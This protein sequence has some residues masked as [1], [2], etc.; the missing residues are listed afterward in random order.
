MMMA[1]NKKLE[2]IAT[3]D[4]H[5]ALFPVDFVSGK[6]HLPSMS[7]I[8]TYVKM[9]RHQSDREILLLDNGDYLQGDPAVYYYNYIDTSAVHIGAK[10]MNYMQYD[11]SCAGNHDFEAG[12]DVFEK[13]VKALNFP[14]MA[15]NVIDEK[16]G[17]TLLPAYT[18]YKR[19]GKTIAVIAL[20]TPGIPNWLPDKLIYDLEFE[21]MIKFAKYWMP[22][23][24]EKEKPDLV[25]GLCHAGTDYTFNNQTDT[26]YKNENAALLTAKQVEGFDIIIAGHDHIGH[27]FTITNKWGKEVTIIAPTARAR[28]FCS[29]E[30]NFTPYGNDIKTHIYTTA[31]L[32]ADYSFIHNFEHEIK[33]IK[34]FFNEPIGI[35]S[36][37]ISAIEG[38]F[39][40]DPLTNLI[41]KVQLEVTDAEISFAAPLSMNSNIHKGMQYRKD[42]F[43]LYKYDNSLYAIE[44]SGK[45]IKD[46]LEFSY[47]Q[48]FNKM[49]DEDDYLLRYKTDSVGNITS[50]TFPDTYTPAYNYESAAGII[51]T[52]DVSKDKGERINI[53]SMS[54]GEPFDYEKIYKVAINSY[55]GTGGG[56]HLTLGAGI[57]E[58]EL[59]QR[60][61]FVSQQDM[62]FYI[63]QWLKNNSPVEID[64]NENWKIIPEKWYKKALKKEY[65]MFSL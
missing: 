18:I 33:I 16:T 26:T 62:K 41:H 19:A 50:Q 31:S 51:Y 34:D 36:K 29:I 25:I 30:V 42:L 48:W 13:F 8:N 53:K 47:W 9:Q 54:N 2:I 24:L 43:K 3:S 22:I 45:E 49:K 7:Q 52:V 21:D 39:K 27:N 37:S 58:K 28:D 23:I 12:R 44:M 35:I 32:P 56:G 38:I 1:Q 65:K 10:I 57:P 59:F 46:M 5:G 60:I 4:I 40:A 63:A 20:T 61:T 55:R 17:Q 64:K 15:A 11:G 6:D 14:C